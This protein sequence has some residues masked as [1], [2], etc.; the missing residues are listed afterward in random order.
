MSSATEPPLANQRVVVTR[1]AHQSAELRQVFEA[2]GARVCGLPLIEITAP[3]DP[4]AF[5]AAATQASQH[6][7]IA[8]TSANAVEAFFDQPIDQ[9]LPPIAV[10]GAATAAALSR[11]QQD[12]KLVAQVATAEGLAQELG[13]LTQGR[14]VL[15]PQATDA[16]PALADAL[17]QAGAQ[18]QPVA[19]YDKRQPPAAHQQALRIFGTEEALGWV[20]FTSPRIARH[21]RQLFGDGWPARRQTL[22]ALSI[23]PVTSAELRRLGVVRC[24]QAP[25][26][27]AAGLLAALL[28]ARRAL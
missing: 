28:G 11:H 24:H 4:A 17:R 14:R 8:F 3:P 22:K 27:S 20:T 23:G 9:S 16:R 1:A 19:A 13:P 26:P 12:A 2:A 5:A 15:I 7:W 25:T 6:D 10:V 21:F 18:V